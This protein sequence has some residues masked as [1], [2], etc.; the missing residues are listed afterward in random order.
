MKIALMIAGVVAFSLV[1]LY[2]ASMARL[3]SLLVRETEVRGVGI[4]GA[5]AQLA[6]FRVV[7]LKDNLDERFAQRH[8]RLLAAARWSGGIGLVVLVFLF[9]GVLLGY[10]G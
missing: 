10:A 4:D 1:V 5:N 2:L 9:V 8:L 6:L 3:A 7:F